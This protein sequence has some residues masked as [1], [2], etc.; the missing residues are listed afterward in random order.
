[1]IDTPAANRSKGVLI[2][3]DNVSD[4]KNLKIIVENLGYRVCG[5][6]PS[7]GSAIDLMKQIE[8]ETSVVL[9]NMGLKGPMDGIETA[10]RI[11]MKYPINL[12][13]LK[14]KD[15]LL[16]LDSTMKN[17]KPYAII[18]KPFN[19][20]IIEHTIREA[21]ESSLG[22]SPH[23]APPVFDEKRGSQRIRA[24]DFPWERADLYLG[25][26][27]VHCILQNI[28]QSGLGILS[29]AALRLGERYPIVI[30]LPE[31]TG[32]VKASVMVRYSLKSDVYTYYGL[33]LSLSDEDRLAWE[34]Y[35]RYRRQ[36]PKN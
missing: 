18:N 35:I 33:Q 31:P 23:P 34:G 15:D 16:A 7:G 8:C 19:L 29:E 2:V 24:L 32:R 13:F 27:P 9:V 17:A 28:S 4:A 6:A 26:Q 12:V 5:I 36:N 1:M 14:S 3:E 30:S 25:G 10:R 11:C 21:F 22:R 20:G